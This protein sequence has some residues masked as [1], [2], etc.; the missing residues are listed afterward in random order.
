[1]G[2]ISWLGYTYNDAKLLFHLE[3]LGNKRPISCIIFPTNKCNF[4]CAHCV[5]YA[6]PLGIMDSFQS[7]DELDL[8]LIKRVVTELHL[9]GARSIQISGGGEPT[10]YKPLA[11]VVKHIENKGLEWSLITNGTKC[12]RII[13]SPTWV[14]ISFDAATD[15]I[16]QRVHRTDISFST[17]LKGV[18]DFA[19]RKGQTTVGGSFLIT[20]ENYEDIAKF[21]ALAK[22][23]GLDYARYTFARTGRG[24]SYFGNFIGEIEQLLQAAE[25]CA[26]DGFRVIAQRDRR[27]LLE[28]RNRDFDRCYYAEHVP[29]IAADGFLYPCCELA[30][31]PRYRVRSLAHK[32]EF[33]ADID[34]RNCPPCFMDERNKGII[35]MIEIRDS[36][37]HSNF[38]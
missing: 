32:I 12:E 7:E 9:V 24:A 21:A 8:S 1:M 23:L 20:A 22:G 27:L 38:L 17:F 33:G 3:Q 31:V 30:Y 36:C 14:R 34:P 16:W 37:K 26:D 4:R 35:Q 5:Y 13:G 15:H 6:N 19:D 10:L 28:Q 29:C 25:S 11:E 2:T 18:A